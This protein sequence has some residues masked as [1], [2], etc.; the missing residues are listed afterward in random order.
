MKLHRV[1]GLVLAVQFSV[2]L[3]A[4]GQGSYKAEAIG[5]APADVPAA[6]LATLDAQ[7]VRVT[8]DQGATLCEVWLRKPLPTNSSP[9]TS[10]DVLFGALTEGAFLGVLHFPNAATDFRSQTI[11]PG[12]YTLRYALIPQDGNH[13][14]VNPTRDTFVLG[15]VSADPGP[16]KTLSFDDLVKLSRQASGT[17]HPGLLVG[18]PASGSSFPSVAKDDSGNWDLQIKGHGASGDLPL[19]FTVAGHWQG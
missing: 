3:S 9:N 13:M 5:A 15:P 2:V 17:P 16:D 8:N 10:S 12:F 6:I 11:K 14:G 18:V 4:F 19:A 7:G 1:L